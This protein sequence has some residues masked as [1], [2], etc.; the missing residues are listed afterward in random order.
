MQQ[1]ARRIV[2]EGDDR[3]IWLQFGRLHTGAG[4]GLVAKDRLDALVPCLRVG[5]GQVEHAVLGHLLDVVVLDVEMLAI[6]DPHQR[7]ARVDVP[8]LPTQGRVEPL[9]CREVP[10][11]DERP[12]VGSAQVG[13]GC[14]CAMNWFIS[15][16]SVDCRLEFTTATQAHEAIRRIT[17]EQREYAKSDQ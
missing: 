4:K 17:G 14:S 7:Q 11:R 10:G 5:D 16:A 12:Q 13:H 3:A 15:P 6:G 9:R 1:D 2:H 8:G